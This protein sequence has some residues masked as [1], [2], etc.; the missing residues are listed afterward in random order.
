L[1]GLF[2]QKLGLTIDVDGRGSIRLDIIPLAAVKDVI[3]GDINKAASQFSRCQSQILRSLNIHP[4]RHPRI[5]FAPVHIGEGRGMDDRL[6]LQL[7][8]P[9]L[10][11]IPV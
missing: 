11:S 1:C 9:L 6:W 8:D 2:S 3:R 7:G 10:Y 5:L 4:P